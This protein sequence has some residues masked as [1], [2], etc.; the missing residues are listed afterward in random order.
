MPVLYIYYCVK[1]GD[2]FLK[3]TL[4]EP[5]NYESKCCSNPEIS[6]TCYYDYLGYIKLNNNNY[7]L[8]DTNKQILEKQF[9]NYN[10]GYKFKFFENLIFNKKEYIN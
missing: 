6:K 7:E 9:E 10:D 4:G 3:K 8:F 5:N 2:C 1:H